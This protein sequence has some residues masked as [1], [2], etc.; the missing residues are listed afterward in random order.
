MHAFGS[1]ITPFALAMLLWQHGRPDRLLAWA[2]LA[3]SCAMVMSV[4]YCRHALAGHPPADGPWNLVSITTAITGAALG[5]IVLF[6]IASLSE[7][8]YAFGVA[9]C[10]VAFCAGSFV[11]LSPR[12]TLI[13]ATIYPTLAP[14]TVVLLFVGQ[15]RVS[16]CLVT[17]V[18]I[19]CLRPLSVMRTNYEALLQLNRDAQWDAQHDPL[20]GLLNRNGLRH[21]WDGAQALV[22]IDL[23]GFKLVNDQHGHAAGDIVLCEAAQ[24]LRRC[25]AASGGLVAR[26][27]GD[28]FVMVMTDGDPS[29][30]METVR[31]ASAALA[32]AYTEEGLPMEGLEIGASMGVAWVEAEANLDAALASAD[33]AMYR[34]KLKHSVVIDPASCAPVIDAR[35]HSMRHSSARGAA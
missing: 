24:R 1:V 7:P 33:A 9:A 31:M 22:F 30:V 29:A 8:A 18:G 14:V 2:I 34:A 26:F 17:F 20:T 5:S 13:R 25:A 35:S 32:V 15:W 6:D 4:T 28:E 11:N 12:S 21:S 19:V 3:A 10:L 23:D 16:V 27:G